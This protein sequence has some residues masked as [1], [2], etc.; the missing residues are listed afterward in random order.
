M[1]GRIGVP[2]LL[3]ILVVPAAV[4]FGVVFA[5]LRKRQP[6]PDAAAWGERQR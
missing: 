5:V 4:V 6:R 1:F 2:E 3:L